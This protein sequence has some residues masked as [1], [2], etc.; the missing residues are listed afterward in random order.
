[1]FRSKRIGGRKKLNIY[2]L[3][4]DDSQKQFNENSHSLN[5]VFVCVLVFSFLFFTQNHVEQKV[6]W[7]GR[8]IYH[9][10]TF[11]VVIRTTLK[12]FKNLIFVDSQINLIFKS[13]F[14]FP[15]SSKWSEWAGLFMLTLSRFFSAFFSVIL[16]EKMVFQFAFF[17]L[18]KSNMPKL[19]VFSSDIFIT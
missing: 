13:W 2:T 6:I 5:F 4:G 10:K 7:I 12:S 9:V 15:I 18:W 11:S 17:S 8:V 19:S 16:S 14:F 3:C 1:M